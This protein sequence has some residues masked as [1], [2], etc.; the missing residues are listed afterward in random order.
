M[1]N[2]RTIAIDDLASLTITGKKANLNIGE[3]EVIELRSLHYY[4]CALGV[5]AGANSVYLGLYRKSEKLPKSIGYGNDSDEVWATRWVE[6]F[7]TESISLSKNGYIVFPKP[8]LLLRPPQMVH[9]YS[10]FIGLDIQM[11]LYYTIKKLPSQELAK[12]MIK[13]HE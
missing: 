2:L 12:L 3:K 10:N 9:Q 7:V 6:K 4:M 1:E 13:D 8:I 5:A 11:R